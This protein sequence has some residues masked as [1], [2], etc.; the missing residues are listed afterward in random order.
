MILIYPNIP[1][2]RYLIF[3]NGNIYD[4][5]RMKYKKWYVGGSGYKMYKFKMIDGKNEGV[6]AHR[7]VAYNYIPNPASKPEVNH[8]DGDKLNCH[9]SN[10]EWVTS[11]E[12]RLH[13]YSTGLI[14]PKKC[15]RSHTVKISEETAI[16]IYLS[17]GIISST[18]L[19]FLFE[20]GTSQISRIWNKQSWTDLTDL[21]DMRLGR[22]K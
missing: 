3:D 12:N 20:I 15:S 11:S 8:I 9:L 19:S 14:K 16:A 5:M 18:S 22:I 17:K 2:G 1:E 4:R 13:A 10:L 7:L 21:V 6:L